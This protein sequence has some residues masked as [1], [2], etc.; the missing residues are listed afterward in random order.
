MATTFWAI[1]GSAG[2]YSGI[3]MTRREAIRYHVNSFMSIDKH[4]SPMRTR[5]TPDEKRQWAVCKFHGDRA[6]RVD[7]VE[8]GR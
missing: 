8:I 5:L 3:S 2:I 6:I 7:V 4:R 1:K